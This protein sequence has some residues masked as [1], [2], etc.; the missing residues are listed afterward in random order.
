MCLHLV[1]GALRPELE[2]EFMGKPWGRLY[3]GTRNHRKIKILA[4][5]LPN[6]WTYWYV[7]IDLAIEIDDEGWIYVSPGVPYTMKELAKELRL[8]RESQVIT[9]TDTLH[10]LGM[11]TLCDKGLLLNS[12]A[13][14]NFISDNST[15]RVQKYRE[16]QKANTPK[17]TDTKRFSNVSET[18]QSRT[19]TETDTEQKGA[20]PKKSNGDARPA[21]SCSHFELPQEY[22]DSLIKDYPGLDRALLFRELG[23]MNDW[24]TD[25]PKKHQRRA[26]GHLK[27]PRAFIRNWIERMEI[28]PIRERPTPT[29]K[30]F[31]PSCPRCQG[32]GLYESG[33][34]PDD[35]PAYKTCDCEA[36]NG[37]AAN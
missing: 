37:P 28:Q 5:R 10:K 24:L 15:P 29:K 34:M 6:L 32:R 14:R 27:N 18:P 12:F 23:R 7:L 26:N 31:D 13:E 33:K 30:T 9:L 20:S 11:I 36:S 22:I 21:F 16:K 35:S 19:D 25:N 3:G 17:E 2:N 8:Y 1:T 4:E